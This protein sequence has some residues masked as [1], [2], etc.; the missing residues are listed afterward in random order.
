MNAV[1]QTVD[2]EPKLV[3]TVTEMCEVASHLK[4]SSPQELAN[5]TDVVKLI[6]TRHNAIE[7]E[8]TT[9]VKPLNDTVK[10]INDRFKTILAPLAEAE[11]G[12][13]SKML[14]YQQ[15]EN[16]KA[17][18]ARRE[19]ERKAREDAERIAKEQ[20]SLAPNSPPP[21]VEVAAILPPPPPQTTRGAFGSTSTLKKVWVYEVE[22][23]QKL[24]AARPD[25]V[26]VDAAKI[27]GLIRGVGGEIPGLKIYQKETIAV[28]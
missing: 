12:V 8:R 24:A 16:R 20:A 6:K 27:N 28:R 25:L 7:E 5:A 22:D 1:A 13:K 11:V 19:A 17:E 15:E 14:A 18:E 3:A 26:M 23:I 21:M 2:N 10:R 9:L 4:V